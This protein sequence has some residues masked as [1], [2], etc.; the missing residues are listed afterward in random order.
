MPKIQ[1]K[2]QMNCPSFERL[3]DF[4]DSRLEEREAARVEAHLASGC[5]VCGETTS[6][7]E[8]V[9]HTVE[10]DDSV[11]PPSWVFKRAVRIFDA[12]KRRS[13]GLTERIGHAIASLVFDSFARP[14][15]VGVRSTETAN[16]QLLYR[17]DDYSIDLQISGLEHSNADVMGQILKE[18][19]EGFE[20]VCGLKLELARH[21]D[22]IVSVVT[23]D[24]GEFKLTGIEQG[25]Y[26]LRVALSEGSITVPNIPVG[27]P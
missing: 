6:W 12:P 14:A 18:R 26:E 13:P 4:V 1:E 5:G 7:Y 21:D 20:S 10:S 15:L 16:R 3:V 2:K 24:I 8:R 27:E 9:R 23:N 19:G 22:V 17:A 25:V 11:A